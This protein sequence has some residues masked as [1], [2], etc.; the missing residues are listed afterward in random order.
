MVNTIQKLK[1]HFEFELPKNSGYRIVSTAE[2]EELKRRADYDCWWTPKDL[3][4]R[5][6]HDLQ[7][8][9]ENILYIPQFKKDLIKCVKY[10]R[11]SGKNGWQFEPKG[12]SKFMRE[13]FKAI[14]N[15]EDTKW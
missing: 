15:D 7:W 5:Y 4:E 6:G 1:G 11:S 8:F 3:K 14:C 12:F 2:F 9:R 10:P 13:N